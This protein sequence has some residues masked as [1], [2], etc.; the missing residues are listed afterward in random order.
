M[1]IMITSACQM[2]C[3][4]CIF[5]CSPKRG[6]H[7]SMDIFRAAAAASGDYDSPIAIGG[8]EPTLHPDLLAMLSIASFLSTEPIFMVTNGTCPE[9]LWNTLMEA[10]VRAKINIYVSNDLWHDSSM[11][12]PWVVRD[13]DRHKL[14]WGA[15]STGH[16][17]LI[18][19]GRAK[20]NWKKLLW[21][22]EQ[23]G[24]KVYTA[25]AECGDPRVSPDGRVWA[26]VP[27]GGSMGMINDPSAVSNAYDAIRN[28]EDK[29]NEE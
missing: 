11:I 5:S 23:S 28:Y 6:Q 2:E 4:H 1:Y 27:G 24:L 22:C 20:R 3:A 14:W 25:E 26:D 7:M 19:R 17:T 8:G 16:R 9:G 29:D 10:R 12:K 21:E 15:P 13:A 18:R